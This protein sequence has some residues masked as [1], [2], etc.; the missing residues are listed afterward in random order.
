MKICSKCKL[1]KSESEFHNKVDGRLSSHCIVCQRLYVRQHYKKNK[2]YYLKKAIKGKL[3]THDE[4]RR[5]KEVPCADCK[6]SYPYYVMDF[7]HV[8]GKKEYLVSKLVNLGCRTKALNEAK[9]CEIVCSNCHRI[10]TFNRQR[11]SS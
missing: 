6:Q 3:K 2:A 10:R 4:F 8:N 9:K 11:G 5:L 1:P 7:D